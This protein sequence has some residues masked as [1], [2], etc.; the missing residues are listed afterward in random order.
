MRNTLK[1]WRVIKGG[2]VFDSEKLCRAG[3]TA[4]LALKGEK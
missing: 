3:S 2:Q 1:I 4:A